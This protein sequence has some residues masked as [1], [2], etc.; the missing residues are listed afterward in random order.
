[1]A[2]TLLVPAGPLALDELVQPAHF[3]LHGL[4]PVALELKRV[5]VEALPGACQR[6]THLLQAL[7]QPAAA[8][9][10]DSHADVARG[11]PE[12]GETSCEVLVLVRVGT[13]LREQLLEVLL[14][15]RRQPVDDLCATPCEWCGE[16]V[17]GGVPRLLDQPAVGDQRLEAGVERAVAERTEHAQ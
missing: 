4:H 13:R 11:L 14:T 1:M 8:A 15:F 12:K 3:A 9:F 6:G 16:G 17:L 5:V 7:L 10:E 2:G